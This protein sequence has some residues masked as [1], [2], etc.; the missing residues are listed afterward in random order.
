MSRIGAL[1]EPYPSFGSANLSRIA[2]KVAFALIFLSLCLTGSAMPSQEK[3]AEGEY[4]MTGKSTSGD[5]TTKTLTRW[6][7]VSRSS[8][9]GYHL[10]S[11]IQG[12]PAG[13]RIVQ[14]EELDSRYVPVAI[15]YELYR[16]QQKVPDLTADCDLSGAIVCTGVS[17]AD[18]ADASTPY[19]LNQPFW[20]W[21]DGVSSIDVAWLL[22]GAVNMAN[23]K[24]G[25][26]NIA[27]LSVFG[28]TAVMLADAVNIASLEALKMPGRTLTVVAPEKP[29]PWELSVNEESPLELVGTETMDLNNNKIVVKH[30]TF[31]NDRNAMQLWA[32]SPSGL[33]VRLGNLVLANYKQYRP[34][35]PE[36]GIEVH[37][38]EHP[39][40]QAH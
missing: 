5:P 23:L 38:Q 14:T 32:A 24:T 37:E 22:G 33:V 6:V 1:D 12:Q 28:G 26:S 17:G 16:G 40:R 20:L 19:K 18:R 29:I 8:G 36:V 27:T 30:Y 13:I 10:E 35:I 34:I 3:I 25:K 9:G 15:G 11:E 7:L 39:N 21:M 2:M 4:Q 31:G